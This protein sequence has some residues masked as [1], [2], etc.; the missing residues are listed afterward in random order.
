VNAMLGRLKVKPLVVELPDGTSQTFTYATTIAVMFSAMYSPVQW[1][2]L[3]ALL[4]QFA[5]ASD[6]ATSSARTTSPGGALR[7][8]RPQLTERT[9][10]LVR[11]VP[12]LG[13]PGVRST[14]YPSIGGS[15]SSLCV[16]TA[17]A[18]SLASYPKVAAAQDQVAPGFGRY[19]AWVGI[20]CEFVGA[21]D[22][23]AYR[24]PWDQ[25]T[26]TPVLVIGTRFDPATPFR[27][28]APYAA[29]FTDARVITVQGWGHTILGKST[30]A[31]QRVATYLI[32]GK[33]AAKATCAQDYRPF[34]D[35]APT[36]TARALQ[37]AADAG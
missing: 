10:E 18:R 34:A 32:T 13:S 24:G 9:S 7:D 1:P 4:A 5:V 25:K 19:R 31:D 29:H 23:D 14:D 36:A 27:F 33:A 3:A 15:L 8:G 16:D 30:C 17:K 6:P 21:R 20:T 37:T 35:P 22:A 2:D 28:T 26:S 12:A 11:Q